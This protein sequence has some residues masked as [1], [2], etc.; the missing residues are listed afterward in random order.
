MSPASS[1]EMKRKQRS[2]GAFEKPTKLYPI[3]NQ[4]RVYH[5][6]VYVDNVVSK[7]WFAWSFYY[8]HHSKFIANNA[9]E[10][11]SQIHTK[12]CNTRSSICK[13]DLNFL[14]PSIHFNW[15]TILALIVSLLNES[16]DGFNKMGIK[17]VKIRFHLIEFWRLWSIFVKTLEFSLFGLLVHWWL[18]YF[19][20]CNLLLIFQIQLLWWKVFKRSQC[21][22]LSE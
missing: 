15:D 7:F 22:V 3:K 10:N 14:Q 17:R 5:E 18:G 12:E 8:Q 1:F 19:Q 13:V 6:R 21:I 2:N 16:V 20:K 4:V 9:T 11:V